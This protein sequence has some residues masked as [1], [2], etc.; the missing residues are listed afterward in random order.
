[1]EKQANFG[2]KRL[3]TM[4]KRGIS[5]AC[6]TLKLMARRFACHFDFISLPALPLLV[7]GAQVTIQVIAESCAAAVQ[8][9]KRR[10]SHGFPSFFQ[11]CS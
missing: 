8:R 6:V 9:L 3:K 1:M 7:K 2:G 4:K 11:R 10:I 5:E